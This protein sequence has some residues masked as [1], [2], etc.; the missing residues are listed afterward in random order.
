MIK[1]NCYYCKK[2]FWRSFNQISEGI[3]YSW[4][5]YC[6]INCQSKAKTKAKE[7]K[8]ANSSCNK[9]FL[10]SPHN[11]A[12]SGICFCSQ[13][14]AAIVS[15]K[16][17]WLKLPKNYCANPNCKKIIPRSNTYCS[18]KC[19]GLVRK[20]PDEIFKERIINKIQQFHLKMDRIPFKKEMWGIYQVA[21]RIFGSW[22][23]AIVA[24]GFKP[25]PVKFAMKYIANDGHKCDSLAEKIIDDWL[26][27]KKISHEIK[28]PYG[29][30]R[31][32][33]DFKINDVYIEY[34][35]LQG[36]VKRYDELVSAKE[37]LWK[38][39]KLK[40]ISIY[41]K[42]LFPKSKLNEIRGRFI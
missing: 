19:Q 8:C 33:A 4:K 35:G 23:N 18:N 12:Q 38:G 27:A 7:F 26:Y 31:M 40:N 17:R 16:N 25:N 21:R 10:R 39:K 15:N 41:P 2:A 5:S 29:L 14:C 3:K 32:T 9:I 1:I 42:D 28:V 24:A 37:K 13:S 34:F 30:N 6:S 20:I 22:N 36:E 11:T